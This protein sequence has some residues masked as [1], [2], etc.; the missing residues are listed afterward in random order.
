MCN[1]VASVVT[2]VIYLISCLNGMLLLTF[3]EDII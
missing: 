3:T 2:D 1:E